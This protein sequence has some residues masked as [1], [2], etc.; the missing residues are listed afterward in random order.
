MSGHLPSKTSQHS[1]HELASPHHVSFDTDRT[2]MPLINQPVPEISQ[3]RISASQPWR[4]VFR[5]HP[6]LAQVSHQR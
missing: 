6:M 4:R 3:Q 1:V 5:R 2:D